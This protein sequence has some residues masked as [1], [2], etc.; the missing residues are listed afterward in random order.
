MTYEDYA[1]RAVELGHSILSS[2]EHGWQ[3]RY[4]EC[5][6]LAKQYGLKFLFAAEAYWVWDR[7][8]EDRSNCHIWIGAKNENGREWINEVL[9]QANEDGFYYQPR[10][11]EELLD[12]LPAGDVWI[13]TACVAGWKY[14]GEEEERIKALWKKLYDKHG[15][16][17]M[18][19]VQYHPSERQ[20]ELNR[21]ILNLRK[22][23]PAPIIM[24]CDSHYIEANGAELRSD[25]LLSKEERKAYD[26]E[27]EWFMD[28]PDGDTAVQRFREQGVLTEAEIT[29]AIDRTNC[30]LEVEEYECDIFD[31]STKLFSLHPEWTQGQKDAEYM[32]LVQQGWEAYKPE[33]DPSLYPVYE[34]AIKEET[35]TVK[36]CR[37]SD[38]F[39]DDYYIMKRGKELGG[40]LTTTGR[41]SCVGFFTNKLLGFTEVDRIAAK[42]KMY[43]ERFMTAERILE[44]QSIPDLDQNVAEQDIFAEGQAQVCGRDHA[45]QML[46]YG[47]QK[48]SAAWKMFA[49]SQN[50]DFATANEV[51]AQIKR[52]E[53][54]LHTVDEEEKDTID[55]MDYIDKRFHDVY[56]RST[57]YQGIITS[58]SPAPC[59]FLLYQGSIRRKIGLVKIKDKI[60]CA[61][62]GHWAEKNHFLKNDLLRVA[63]V[64]LINRGY[65]RAGLKVPTVNELLDMCP[66]DD[67]VWG[68]YRKGCTL[69]INQVE[70]P[71]TASRVGVY[72]PTNISELCAFIAAI[73]PGFK[74][75]YKTF[76]S[77][78][79][80]SYDVKPFD[81]LLRTDELPQS[82]CLYQEQQMAA[83]NF[84]GF[85]MKECYAAVK[86]IAKKRKEKVLAYRERFIDGFSKKLIEQEHLDEKTALEKTDMVWKIIEDSASYSFNACVSGDTKIRRGSGGGH[87]YKPT[88]E[89]MFLIRNDIDYAK[90]TNHLP[91]RSK[92]MRTYGC[93]LSMFEDGKIHENNIVDIS[94]AG[95]RQTYRV[96][97]EN[98]SHIDCTDN[99]KFP[100]IRGE[101]QLRELVVGDELYVLGAYEKNTHKYTFTNGNYES[102]IPKPGQM[103]FQTH[104]DGP[105]VVYNRVREERK[106]EKCACEVCGKSYTEDCRFELHHKD[107]NRTHN[108]E[109]NFL[110]C[111]VSCHKK[112]HYAHGRTGRYEKGIPTLRS[113]IVSIEPKCV[114]RVYDVEMLSPYHNFVTDTGIVT[115]N[116]HS[117]CVSLDSLYGAWLKQHH[118]LAFYETFMRIMDEKGDKDKLAAAKDEA[119]SYFNIKFPPFKFGQDNRKVTADEENNAISNALTSI[120]G[121]NKA[122]AVALYE[123][124]QEPPKYLSDVLL[125]L[126]PKSIMKS[127]T[128]PLAQ[129]S[130]FSSY[131][132]DREVLNIIALCEEFGYGAKASMPRERVDNS[133]L[134]DIVPKYADGLKKDGQ[135]ATRYTFTSL[136]MSAL[137][138]EKKQL[139]AALKKNPTPEL[140]EQL[141]AV[142][143]EIAEELK[144]IVAQAL[145][146]CEDR[147]LAAGIEDLPFRVKIENQQE[148]LGYVDIR[149][150][151]EEDRRLVLVSDFR[152]LLSKD[153]GK[154]WGYACFTQSLGSG[155]RIRLTLRSRQYDQ[156]PIKNGSI[157]YVDRCTKNKSGYWYLDQYHLV[158]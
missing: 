58:W 144:R 71:G 139:A 116:S 57:E 80:F 12:L 106:R 52:Y 81:E 137:K 11:D 97:L 96:T 130:Y 133:F 22:E 77:R 75:M 120:K 89:E 92:Y 38:Y 115:S 50:I 134:A 72:A 101:L 143:Q 128:E 150:G 5:H 124:G 14:L 110:W 149:T 17:F 28:Y 88:I 127:T 125:A 118:P 36:Q 141:I 51:S 59:A 74:S 156:N 67:P 103:G 126:R 40:H 73:R 136:Q 65:H 26:D 158:G 99:H 31:D 140:E 153:T 3:G 23:I 131:G 91:L 142:E 152:P 98:G 4:I 117:Y 111:C 105:S 135:P 109:D 45:V 79:D 122:A 108:T 64:D 24:G 30:F 151:K 63:V 54:K 21:Y 84:A 95:E 13:T 94:Y 76:E 157:I 87:P 32:R 41:G 68:I 27:E 42:V 33:V 7:H 46:A 9:S 78:Q 148:I 83:L 34:Q 35:D 55:I 69:G 138:D 20:K 6:D 62:D 93:G 86:N 53:N 48:A 123:I 56:L 147:V 2:C 1:K 61:M 15:D 8:E 37:M 154:P 18:F 114:E 82:F 85:P 146:E 132:N 16:N 119:E 70:Q 121:F 44:T 129:I 19:E 49:K 43:P 145:R 155:K 47:T 90:R 25:F 104:P 66:P 39:I 100:T 107:F 112:I 29:E 113:K 10:L 60:C 102:N